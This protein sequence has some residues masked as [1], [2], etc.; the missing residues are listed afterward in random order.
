[1]NLVTHRD[2]DQPMDYVAMD[3]TLSPVAGTSGAGGRAGGRCTSPPSAQ[4]VDNGA[5][6]TARLATL[7]NSAKFSDIT[8]NVAGRKTFHAHRLLLANASDVFE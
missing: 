2:R 3:L 7:C 1:M 5:Q 6:C 8:L 4:L